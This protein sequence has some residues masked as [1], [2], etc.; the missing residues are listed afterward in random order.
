MFNVFRA[1]A[2]LVG[3]LLLPLASATQSVRPTFENSAIVR[4]V[5]LGGSLTSLSTTYAVKALKDDANA[6]IV[7]L[8]EEEYKFTSWIQAKIKGQSKPLLFSLL[9]H[10]KVK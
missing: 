6:Y 8:S 5:E 3:L 7:A 9:G 10:D 1:G 4:T 2:A